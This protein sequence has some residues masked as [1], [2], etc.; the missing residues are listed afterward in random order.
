MVHIME[1]EMGRR[2][3]K[4]LRIERVRGIEKG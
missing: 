3:N 4:I 2:E 1:R